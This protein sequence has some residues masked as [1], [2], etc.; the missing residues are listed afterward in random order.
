MAAKV[1]VFEQPEIRTKENAH[2]ERPTALS[3]SRY[4]TDGRRHPYD[5]V[6]WEKRSA[7]ITNEKGEAVFR[8]DDVE[9]PTTWSQTATNVVVSKYFNGKIGTPKRESS[10][11]GLIERVAATIRDW[12]LAGKYFSSSE[13]AKIFYEELAHLLVHQKLAFNSPVWFNCGIEPKPQCSACQPYHAL[14]DTVHGLMPIGEI[15]E[16]NLIGLPVYDESGLTQVVAVKKNGRKAVYR[17]QC[18]DGF[19]VEATGD[20][21]VCAHDVRRKHTMQWR[22]VDELQAGM[23]MRIYPHAPETITSPASPLEISEAALAGWLQADGFVG[24]YDEGTNRSLTIEFITADQC[25]HEWVLSHL[26]TVFPEHHYKVREVETED[27]SLQCRRIR[28]YGEALRPFVEKYDLLKRG[29]EIRVPKALWTASND[30]VVAYLRSVFQA[31]GYASTHGRSAHIA[32]AVISEDWIHDLQVLLTRLG[33]YSRLR[34]KKDPREDRHDTLELD[35]SILSERLQFDRKIGFL[36]ERKQSRLEDSLEFD[37]K[38]CPDVRFAEIVSIAPL[39]EMEVYDIQT[40]SSHYLTNSVLVHNCFIN[41]VEDRMESILELAKTEGMLFKW[42]SGTGSNLSTLRSSKEK[43]SGGGVASGPV[44]F[45]RGFDAFAGVIKSGGKTRRAAK[46]VILN[47]DHPDIEEFINSKAGEEK[48]A[49]ALI[50]AGYDGSFNGEAYNSIFF[51]NANH[52]VRVTD[53]FMQAAQADRDW[54]TRAVTTKEVMETFR[55]RDLMKKIA[56]AAWLCGDPGVQFDTTT[57]EWHTCANTDRIYASNPCFTGDT[58][59]L[60]NKGLIGFREL[61]ER[62]NHGEE[63]QVATDNQ[64]NGGEGIQLTSPEQYMITGFNPIVRLSFSNGMEMR[65][66]KNHR[67]FTQN[68]GMV[69]AAELTAEDQVVVQTRP[70]AFEAASWNMPVPADFETYRAKGDRHA[71]I[72]LPERWTE[73]FA[74]LLGHLVGDGSISGNVVSWIYGSEDDKEQL[75]PKHSQTL[76]ALTG[77]EPHVTVMENKTL[78]VRMSRGAFKRYVEA[79]GVKEVHAASKVVPASIFQAPTAI[80]AAF[81]KGLFTADGCVVDQPNGTRYVGLGSKSKTLLQGAQMLLATFG[82]F[83]RIYESQS[84]GKKNFRYTR[85]DGSEVTYESSGPSYDLRIAG[86]SLR[87]FAKQIG[88]AT[89][90]SS[91]KLLDILERTEHYATDETISLVSREDDGVELTYNL[92]EPVNH[93]YIVNGLVVAN[94]SEYMFLNDTACNL[95]SLNLMKFRKEDGSFDAEAFKHAVHITILA[96]EILVDNASYPTPRIE[97]NSHEFRPL[98]LGYANLGAL[99]MASGLPYDS[100]GGRAYSAMITALMHGQAYKTSALIASKLGPFNSF[101]KNREPMLRVI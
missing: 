75:L 89:Q 57:N 7:L 4:L 73:D 38:I 5:E 21:L 64:T 20:H 33:I 26:Q 52:S 19:F 45:M 1:A 31:E 22:R 56:D 8:Q 88:F 40:R 12:G 79:L 71:A 81:L 61:I 100:E 96:Q 13:D 77:E 95:A 99:L 76:K 24:Q 90:T 83:S 60:T 82:I 97:Q 35:I 6:K 18:N 84:S 9:V 58:L 37:G 87:V 66:T 28:L 14:I 92:T 54:Q 30:A 53:E 44:S 42:G 98:G 47:I 23:V 72:A 65:C 74:E 80:G 36:S 17:V 43:L 25:E 3:V 46:M 78:Q 55:A 29:T 67:L 15:V 50:D 16:K 49:W 34:R 70:V 41:S 91:G 10:V 2:P 69:K 51:Q 32:I 48:K 86:R 63:F 39:G 94:C 93:S 11:R 59:V 27:K 68:R 85:R 62:V 101:E